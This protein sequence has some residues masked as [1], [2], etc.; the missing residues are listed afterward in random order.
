MIKKIKVLK[1]IGKFYNFS[2]S[3]NELD[4]SKNTILYAHNG[5]GKSTL[6]AVLK[7]L[8]GDRPEYILGR[9]TLGTT[10]PSKAVIAFETKEVYVFNNN[11]WDPPLLG[12]NKILIFDSEFIENNIY[13]NTI[14]HDHKKNL[15]SIIIGEKGINLSRELKDLNEKKKRF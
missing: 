1:N 8:A 2:S 11:K 6:V 15:H 4:L 12:K 5:Y 14:E 7:S 13:T 3:A 9:K 10:E